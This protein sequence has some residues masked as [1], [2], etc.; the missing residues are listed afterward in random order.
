[1]EI[2]NL[3]QDAWFL[4]LTAP[5]VIKIALAVISFVA[6]LFFIM[7][8]TAFLSYFLDRAKQK[9]YSKLKATHSNYVLETLQ[10]SDILTE[11]EVQM[12]FA[13]QCG[14]LN[15]RAYYSLIPS[16]QEIIEEQPILQQSPN[17]RTLISALG[18]DSHLENKLLFSSISSK[19]KVFHQL[20]R[21]KVLI[22]D[23]KIL[24]YTFSKNRF[25]RKAARNSYIGVSNNNPFKFFDQEDNQINNWDQIILMEQ[26][27]LHHKNNLPNFS[28]WL[29]YS[30]NNSQ[31]IFLVKAASYFRQYGSVNIL[32]DLLENE[33]HDIR[34]EAIKALGNM[35]IQKVEGKLI[36]LY[37]T[38]P[39]KCKDA[40]VEAIFQINSKTATAFLKEAFEHSSQ[41]ESKKLIA[42]A[43]Y[44]YEEPEHLVFNDMLSNSEG[45]NKTILEHVKN[46]L[47]IS[48]LRKP[49][50]NNVLILDNRAE[51]G[52]TLITQSAN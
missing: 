32:I 5:V 45:F 2:I 31:T 11:Q 30:K 27:E 19:L 16:V 36:E 40:I 38:Q 28:N 6:I 12:E 18:I 41:Y 42:E 9:S 43:L 23:S 37:T 10:R 25:I 15:R 35:Q 1:M 29:K 14:K 4:F 33:N 34:L 49:S 26:L 51:E 7:L 24:P 52:D 13:R 44:F 39:N 22:A 20:S 48:N 50:E 47:N 8:M 21:F 3:L 46:P 17:Y